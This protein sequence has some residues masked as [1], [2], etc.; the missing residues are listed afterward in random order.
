MLILKLKPT[1][2]STEK[3]WTNASSRGNESQHN[4]AETLEP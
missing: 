4:M 3:E 1:S 2:S